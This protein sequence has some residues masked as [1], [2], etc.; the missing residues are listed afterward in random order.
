MDLITDE[1]VFA[2]TGEPLE[3][4]LKDSDSFRQQMK[5]LHGAPKKFTRILSNRMN[6]GKRLADWRRSGANTTFG[7]G[8]NPTVW[9]LRT[10]YS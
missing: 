8:K 4:R 2:R 10:G 5:S 1:F 3:A 9:G 7:M 6:A